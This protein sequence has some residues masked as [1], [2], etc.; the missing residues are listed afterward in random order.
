MNIAF[1][2]PCWRC[3]KPTNRNVKC[4][5][6]CSKDGEIPENQIESEITE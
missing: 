3:K 5:N 6:K 2:N 4:C 1:E